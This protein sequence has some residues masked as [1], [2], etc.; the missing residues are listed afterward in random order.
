MEDAEKQHNKQ[1]DWL[2][3]YQFQKGHSGNPNGRP[4][5]KSL[6]T[7]ARELLES[8]PDEEKAEFLKTLPL[9]LIWQMSEGRPD[10]KS[11]VKADVNLSI[12]PKDKNKIKNAIRNI[13]ADN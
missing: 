11:E 4:K 3:Q 7:F 1:Y 10:S 6:K 13:T 12:D 2:K 8:M 5:G 9:D